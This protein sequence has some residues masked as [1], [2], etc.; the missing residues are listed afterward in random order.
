M[1]LGRLTLDLYAQIGM[2]VLVGVAAKN[3][4]LIVELAKEQRGGHNR[5]CA[6]AL[7]AGDD[8]VVCLYSGPSAAGSSRRS[9][10]YL[11]FRRSM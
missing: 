9:S 8:D 5:R 7:S 3:G 2:M 11:S 1:V 4:I 6:S 10:A